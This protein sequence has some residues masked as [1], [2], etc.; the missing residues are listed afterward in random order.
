MSGT[1]RST[2]TFDAS[3]PAG[4]FSP[5]VPLINCMPPATPPIAFAT[6]ATGTPLQTTQPAAPTVH[7]VPLGLCLKKPRPLPEHCSTVATLSTPRRF[8]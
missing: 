3:T 5:P 4:I 6:A 8:S 1:E 7:G 2:A